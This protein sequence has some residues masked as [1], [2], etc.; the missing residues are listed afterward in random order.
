MERKKFL[1]GFVCGIALTLC[2]EMFTICGNQAGW[3]DRLYQTSNGS[4]K[5]TN[6]QRRHTLQKLG[7]LEKYIDKFYLNDLTADAYEDGLYKGLISGLHDKYAAYYNKEE[8]ESINAMNEGKYVGIGCAISYDK[9]TNLFTVIKVYEGSPAEESGMKTGDELITI[10]G[11]KLAGKTLNDVVA[12]IKGEEGTKVKI[13]VRHESSDEVTEL[14]ATRK[15]VETKTV[16]YTM[17]ENRVGYIAVS[18]FK[19]TTVKQFNDA[20]DI[21]QKEDM[22]GLI[23]DVRNNGGGALSAVVKMTDRLLK[24]GLIVYTRDKSDKGEDY[25]AEDKKELDL[26]MV[27]LVNENSASASEVFAGA[28]KDHKKATLVG[29]RTYGKGIV[30]SIYSLGDGSA[31]KLT[32]SKYYTPN[33]YNIHEVG[34]EPDIKVEM[35]KNYH[36][37]EEVSESSPDVKKDNQLQAAIACMKS[38][39]GG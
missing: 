2:L 32:T 1:S 29:T 31:V 11:K 26:P 24:K 10:D 38:K 23:L 19:D 20:V 13:G 33:G 17:L 25:Y 4:E 28:L 37:D 6:A 15:E 22:K 5:I 7:V 3:F 16:S 30:Q 21:L 9:E 35:N 8:Y 39:M 12:F 18:G 14:E 34:I 27:L 36:L